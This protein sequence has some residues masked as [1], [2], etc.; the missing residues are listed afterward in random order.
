MS[1]NKEKIKLIKLYTA[2]GCFTVNKKDEVDLY[3]PHGSS[4]RH[5]VQLKKKSP[6]S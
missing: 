3:V 2:V 4:P 6:D 1:N 5:S